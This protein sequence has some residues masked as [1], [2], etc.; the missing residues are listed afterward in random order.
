MFTGTESFKRKAE[1]AFALHA[2]AS[3]TLTAQGAHRAYLSMGG[4]PPRAAIL[5]ARAAGV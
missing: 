1:K 3:S 2:D 4:R 5:A